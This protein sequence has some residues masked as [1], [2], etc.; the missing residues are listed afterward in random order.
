MLGVRGVAGEC[1]SG[2]GLCGQTEQLQILDPLLSCEFQ[3]SDLDLC[4]CFLTWQIL[5]AQ[6]TW[7]KWIIYPKS[8]GAYSRQQMLGP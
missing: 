1:R 4:A 8:S 3:T 2:Y 7:G 5:I 6:L